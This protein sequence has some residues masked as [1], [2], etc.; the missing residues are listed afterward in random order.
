MLHQV[1]SEE[2]EGDENQDDQSQEHNEEDDDIDDSDD[3]ASKF[4][5]SQQHAKTQMHAPQEEG[6]LSCK[7]E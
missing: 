6:H 5:P 3:H 4:P 7:K 2:N 1:N